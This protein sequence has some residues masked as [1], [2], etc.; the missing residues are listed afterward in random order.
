MT[1]AA[2]RTL[3]MDESFHSERP[4]TAGYATDIAKH[5]H[6]RPYHKSLGSHTYSFGFSML[7]GRCTHD[8][9]RYAPPPQVKTVKEARYVKV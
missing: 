7:S 6:A 2:F 4:P 3:T 1:N 8:D 5:T 9:R